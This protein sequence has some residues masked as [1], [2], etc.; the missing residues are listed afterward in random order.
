MWIIYR[1]FVIV[2]DI[3][4]SVFALIMSRKSMQTIKVL[5]KGQLNL[6]ACIGIIALTVLKKRIK[7][8]LFLSLLLF[9]CTIFPFFLLYL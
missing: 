7:I 8:F 3:I 1:I 2:I 6:I 4:L 9:R 5:I